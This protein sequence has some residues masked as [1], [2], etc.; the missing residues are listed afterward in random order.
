MAVQ[1]S[2]VA[3]GPYAPLLAEAVADAYD[4]D[5][6]DWEDAGA[7]FPDGLAAQ[8]S[9]LHLTASLEALLG[10]A[11]AINHPAWSSGT[12]VLV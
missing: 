11:V 7:Q 9:V 3:A 1:T 5:D 6:T 8:S 2:E 4:R 12:F 10:S